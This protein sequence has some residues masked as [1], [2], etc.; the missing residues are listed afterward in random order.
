LNKKES[1]HKEEIDSSYLYFF[2]TL[3]KKN[4]KATR[5]A[6]IIIGITIFAI[7]ARHPL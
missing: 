5:R 2:K 4:P 1:L 6:K 7:I 3:K